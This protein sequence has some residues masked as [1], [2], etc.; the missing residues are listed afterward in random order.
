MLATVL[1]IC[2]AFC[3]GEDKGAGHLTPLS[4]F[5]ITA[6]EAYESSVRHVKEIKDAKQKVALK[7]KNDVMPGIYLKI[8]EEMQLGSFTI[9]FPTKDSDNNLLTFEANELIE[10]ELTKIGFKII[11][12]NTTLPNMRLIGWFKTEG[13]E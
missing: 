3:G 9:V 7:Q 5:F 8:R 12:C 10:K 13:I 4:P 6:E 11:D 1:V 2:M